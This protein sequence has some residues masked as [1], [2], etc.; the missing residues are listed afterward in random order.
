MDDTRVSRFKEYRQSMI[1]E[2]AI[3]TDENQGSE[4]IDVRSTTSTLPMETVMKAVKEEGKKDEL[5]IKSKSKHVG[6]VLLKVLITIILLAG[7]AILG[8]FAWR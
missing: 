2:G 7:L 5:Q 1:K 3:A 4:T 8:Y 6:V